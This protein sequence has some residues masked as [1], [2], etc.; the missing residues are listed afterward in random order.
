[1]PNTYMC[2]SC[3]SRG[4]ARSVSLAAEMSAVCGDNLSLIP[5]ESACTQES[6]SGSR[7]EEVLTFCLQPVQIC[8]IQGFPPDLFIT[9][10]ISRTV[11]TYNCA[12]TLTRII[13][14]HNYN[15]LLY[16]YKLK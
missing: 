9:A 14:Y 1:M 6:E 5:L 13:V 12:D 11:L 10:L 16:I 15:N 2:K 3:T 8:I 7:L 4:L